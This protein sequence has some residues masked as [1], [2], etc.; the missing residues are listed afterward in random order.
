MFKNIPDGFSISRC[1]KKA[2]GNQLSTCPQCGADAFVLYRQDDD[3]CCSKCV[4][5]SDSEKIQLTFDR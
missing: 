1:K 2:Y 4:N 5:K 3:W